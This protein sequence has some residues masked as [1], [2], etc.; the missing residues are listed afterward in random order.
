MQRLSVLA[1][2]V[3]LGVAAS[4]TAS[5]YAIKEQSASLLGTAFAGAGSSARDPSV[6]F[7]NPAGIGRLDGVRFTGSGSGI[8]AR[9]EFNNDNSM[10]APFGV[11]IP[12]GDGGDAGEDAVV[13][14]FYLS[15]AA[16]DVFHFGVGVNAPFGLTNEYSEDWVGRYHA[17]ESTLETININ[18]V[19]AVKPISWLSLGAGVQVQYIDTKLTRAIDFGS[20]LA[21]LGVPGAAPFGSDGE[22]KLRASD[23]GVGFTAGVMIEPIAGT[24]AGLSYRSY[25]DHRLSGDAG[26]KNVPAPLQP[27]PLFQNQNASSHVTTP[28][29]VDLSLYQELT[30]RWAVMGDVQW[31]NWSRFHEL[32]VDFALPGVPDDVTREKWDDSWFF[33]LGTQYAPLERLTLRAGVAYDQTPVRDEFRTARLPDQD[34]FW[35][36]GG[37]GYAF[38][39][40][41]GADLGY[42]HIFVR[43]ADIKENVAVGPLVYQLHGQ[44]DNAIDIV[45]MQAN[46]KF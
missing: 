9:T 45:S 11:P 13:P 19:V 22:V 42:T 16:G 6:L 32:R 7:F 33:A 12:G 37:I 20:I 29:S 43:D 30:D 27:S 40:W 10:L 39:Q 44:Y 21:G 25:I 18:P 17:I 24:R 46:F 41:I 5:G 36:A 15:A 38:N 23:W 31:T 34:R 28:D 4:A 3:S 14:A 1:F 2:A 35:V 26:F 8:F